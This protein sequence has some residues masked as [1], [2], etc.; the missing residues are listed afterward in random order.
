MYSQ[1][2]VHVPERYHEKIKAA[3]TKDYP[4]S[5]KIDLTKDGEQVVL[6]TPGQ[7]LKITRA[8][9][10]GKKVM[11][12]RMSRKQARANVQF[13]GG[14]LSMLMKLATKA[15]PT[16]LGGLTTGLLGGLVEKAV[17]GN[18]LFLGKRGYG[19]ARIDFTEEGKGIML[20]PVEN[21]NYDGVYLKH[22]GQI[23]QGKGILLGEN[24]PFKNF[25]IL[26]LIL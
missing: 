14:F 3:V 24:S 1:L 17:T 21:E 8:L 25:P 19:T 12:L 11:T 9:N 4:V 10:E 2:K 20:T 23:Y 7:L 18:G 6:L 5:I 22:N 16:L 13:E 26:G 15:L